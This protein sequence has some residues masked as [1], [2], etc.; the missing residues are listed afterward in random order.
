MLFFLKVFYLSFTCCMLNFQNSWGVAM[1]NNVFNVVIL[2]LTLISTGCGI[3]S[4]IGAPMFNA[5]ILEINGDSVIVEPVDGEDILRS[6][7]RLC[8]SSINLA[9]L[10]IAIGDIVSITYNGAVRETYPGQIDVIKWS[11][12]EKSLP[13]SSKLALPP[14]VAP[15]SKSV[16]I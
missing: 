10:D 2:V 9:K 6:C 12:H 13:I 14:I 3:I 11:L 4:S 5:K 16:I 15:I 1:K 7:D 8:F